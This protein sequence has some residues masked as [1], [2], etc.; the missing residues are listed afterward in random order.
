MSLPL[1]IFD[2]NIVMDIWLGRAN[3]EAVLLVDLAE[4]KKVELKIP[5]FVVI[6]FRGTALRWIREQRATLEVMRKHLN[7]WGRT[8]A[9]GVVADEMRDRSKTLENELNGLQDNVE[10]V[11]NRLCAAATIVEHRIE[12]HFKGDLRYLGGYPPDRP[13]DGIKDCRIYEAVLDIV[14]DDVAKQ[15]VRR[16]VYVTKDADFNP[17][18]EEL[19]AYNVELSNHPGKLYGEL[20]RPTADVQENHPSENPSDSES[21]AS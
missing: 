12:L 20:C 17:L 6:E 7:E 11:R 10:Q 14:K 16:R 15:K 5:G 3:A 13:V 19:A 4:E 8:Q 2:T 21:P 1:L 9:L 18:V